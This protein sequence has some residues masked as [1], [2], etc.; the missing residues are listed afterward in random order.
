MLQHENRV[1]KF[2]EQKKAELQAAQRVLTIAK[3]IKAQS[4]EDSD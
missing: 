3:R 1:E 4:Q 2:K